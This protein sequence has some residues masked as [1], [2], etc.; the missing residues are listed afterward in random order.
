MDSPNNKSFRET[1]PFEKRK[2]ECTRVLQKFPDRIPV[3]IEKDTRCRSLFQLSKTKYLI[4]KELNINQ[5][6]FVLR[7]RIKLNHT[8]SLFLFLEDNTLVP[9]SYNLEDVYQNNKSPDG[10]LYLTVTQQETFG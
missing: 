6:L 5:L 4:P 3:I 9:S 1:H 7:K 10:F 8:E 2:E